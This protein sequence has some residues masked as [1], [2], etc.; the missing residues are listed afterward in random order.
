MKIFKGVLIGLALIISISVISFL[1][2]FSMDLY[3]DNGIV[4]MGY[5]VAIVYEDNSPSLVVASS[6]GEIYAG[7]VV[8]FT[9]EG[10]EFDT[11]WGRVEY[12][13]ISCLVTPFDSDETLEISKDAV[14][15]TAVFKSG[16]LGTIITILAKT[17][18]II[19]I[20]VF[21]LLCL[22]GY[23]VAQLIFNKKS[24]IV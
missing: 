21:P 18:V 12:E 1:T 11:Y 4:F 5:D 8:N 3:K 9:L 14:V 20:I 10:N 17:E 22:L 16:I 13:D 23:V 24:G 7:A 2:W 15:A 19:F 6:D